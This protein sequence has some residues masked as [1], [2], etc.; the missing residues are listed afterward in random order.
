[1]KNLTLPGIVIVVL[2]VVN[3]IGARWYN[4]NIKEL[5]F[6][7]G[8]IL[9]LVGALSSFGGDAKGSSLQGLGMTNSQYVANANL[10]VQKKLDENNPSNSK[11]L[12]ISANYSLL[13]IG[14]ILFA[15]SF[16]L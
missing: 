5:L 15:F 12:V 13:G 2:C 9:L 7:E 14:A 4:L 6:F 3:F 10:E 1:M 8:L 11:K 16:F